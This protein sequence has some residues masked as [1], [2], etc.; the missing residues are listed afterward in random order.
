MTLLKLSILLFFTIKVKLKTPK[1]KVSHV[2]KSLCMMVLIVCMEIDN[3]IRYQREFF[4]KRAQ[5]S[6]S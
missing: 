6:P 5:Q 3:Q 2:H 4:V 1:K